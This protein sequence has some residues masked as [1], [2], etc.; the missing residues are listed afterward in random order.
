MRATHKYLLGIV[1]LFATAGCGTDGMTKVKGRI[2]YEGK[3]VVGR[4][5]FFCEGQHRSDASFLRLN[6]RKWRLYA[7]HVRA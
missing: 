4:I 5:T 7:Q 1:L 3:S 2:T 6:R